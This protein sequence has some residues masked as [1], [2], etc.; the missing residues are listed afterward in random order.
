MELVSTAPRR[1]ALL[2]LAVRLVS[3]SPCNR[4]CCCCSQRPKRLLRER[5]SSLFHSR[6]PGRI[7]FI[8]G[9]S[10]TSSYTADASDVRREGEK[11]SVTGVSRRSEP[12]VLFRRR[13]IFFRAPRDPIPHLVIPLLGSDLFLDHRVSPAAVGWS[14]KVYGCFLMCSNTYRLQ[15]PWDL[16][17]DTEIFTQDLVFSFW[18]DV[19]HP[20]DVSRRRMGWVTTP[21]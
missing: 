14:P 1:R 2:L 8:R 13:R 12:S 18:K 9:E 10:V 6:Q 21:G 20:A 3:S 19:P 17:W 5:E 11:K 15:P 7:A 4:R 16:Q